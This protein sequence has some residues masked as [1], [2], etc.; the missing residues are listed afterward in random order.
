MKNLTLIIPAKYEHDSLPIF[1][2][3]LKEFN[4]KI[5]IVMEESDIKT[6]E[7]L[8]NFSN[9]NIIFQKKKGYG[10]AIREGID[11]SGT[12]YS[13]IINADGSM[14]PVYLKSMLENCRNKD[15]IFASRYLKPGGGSEDD[16]LLTLIGN[17]IFSSLGNILFN[18]NLSDILFTYILGKTVSFKSLK[19]KSDDFRL[20]VEIPIKAKK[21]QLNYTSI[22][23]FERKRFA[24]T[25]KVSELKDGFLILCGI[26]SYLFI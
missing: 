1:L 2:N 12:E 7:S 3:E 20:C 6:R 25:K 10:S 16:T 21:N 26:L 9:V 24:G 4:C 23:C 5:I 22:P 19:L 11:K 8:K 15:L 17:K 13:C 14:N 18:L